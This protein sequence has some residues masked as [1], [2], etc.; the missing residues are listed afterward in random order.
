VDDFNT[1]TRSTARFDSHAPDAHPFG[2]PVHLAPLP[3]GSVRQRSLSSVSLDV[4]AMIAA[5]DTFRG[6]APVIF[7]IFVVCLLVSYATTSQLLR[8]LRERHP[9]V[10]DS[11]GQPTLFWNNSMKNSFAVLGFILG[12]RFRETHDSEVI[13]LGRFL[14][15]FSYAYWAFFIAVVVLGFVLSAR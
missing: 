8:L 5:Q 3:A 15:V 14:R 12:G 6:F 11:L 2:L 1:E 10:Y 4:V 7:L 13:R 9:T